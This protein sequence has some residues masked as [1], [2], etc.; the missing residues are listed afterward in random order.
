MAASPIPTPFDLMRLAFGTSAMLAEAQAV[1]TLRTLGLVGVL[2]ADEG[3]THRMVSEK[4]A[5]FSEAQAAVL[6]A[7]LGGASPVALA[8][9]ALVPVRRCTRAN[10]ARLARGAEM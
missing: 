6:G 2:R 3:E 1:F 8:E 10:V 4:F 7:A 5:A 9:A